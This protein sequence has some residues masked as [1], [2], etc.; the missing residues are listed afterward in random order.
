MPRGFTI[1]AKTYAALLKVVRK[2]IKNRKQG[3]LSKGVLFLHDNALPHIGHKVTDLF[4]CFG[5]EVSTHAP[6]SPDLV[7]S[8]YHL[9]PALKGGLM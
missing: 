2:R 3:L 9:L 6:Y 4:T 1:T 8:D 7:P 5:W